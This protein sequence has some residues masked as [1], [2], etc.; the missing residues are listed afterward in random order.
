MKYGVLISLLTLASFCVINCTRQVQEQNNVT[1]VTGE[2]KQVEPDLYFGTS[3]SEAEADFV[4]NTIASNYADIKFARLA[5]TRSENKRL[6]E[7]AKSLADDHLKVLNGLICFAH[8]RGIV[9]PAE[10]NFEA[11]R[12]IRTLEIDD[13]DKFERRWC[14]ALLDKHE[15][16]LKQFE[17]MWEQTEDTELR[18]WIS[19]TLPEL[20]T[21]LEKLMEYKEAYS[22]RPQVKMTSQERSSF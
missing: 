11:K 14:T 13:H 2:K 19:S 15:T 7:I 1:A 20:I 21:H 10:E 16:A 6:Q 8:K 22:T 17:Y 5:M 9:I 12:T 3:L 18:E 4:A